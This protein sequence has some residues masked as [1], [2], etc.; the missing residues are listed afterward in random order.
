MK[1]ELQRDEVNTGTNNVNLVFHKTSANHLLL[2]TRYMP[3][4]GYQTNDS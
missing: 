1:F 3:S 2:L 4:Q